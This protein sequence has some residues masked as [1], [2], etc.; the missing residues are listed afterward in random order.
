MVVGNA[1]AEANHPRMAALPQ[2]LQHL[3]TQTLEVIVEG[4][5]Y[6]QE[7]DLKAEWEALLSK[8][9]RE[10]ETLRLPTALGIRVSG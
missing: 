6:P 2:L 7:S 10:A 3:P 9:E 1:L 5:H 8:R 4:N